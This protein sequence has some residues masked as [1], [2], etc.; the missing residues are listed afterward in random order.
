MK[1][2]GK[3]PDGGNRINTFL[4]SVADHGYIAV[5]EGSLRTNTSQSDET[6][7]MSNGKIGDPEEA[8]LAVAK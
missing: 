3:Y 2:G 6:T 5:R 4:T 1:S 7:S 8:V